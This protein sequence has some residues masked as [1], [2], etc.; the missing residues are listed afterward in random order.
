MKIG[1]LLY[2]DAEELDIVGPW[3]MFTVW[4]QKFGGP[5]HCLTI[6]E[7]GQ[8]VRCAKGMRIMADT[9]IADCP[10]L[11]VLLV[12]G[13]HGTFPQ[14]E[15]AVFMG[16]VREQAQHCRSV[17]SVCTGSFILERA[18]LLTGLQATTY[19]SRLDQL[20]RT[21]VGKVPEERFLLNASD[22][23]DVWTSAGVSA[24]I[25]MSLAFIARTAGEKT[26][27]KVQLYAEY[28]PSTQ[29]YGTAHEQ[30]DVPAYLSGNT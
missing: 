11:D 13:G 21:R 30:P 26:A 10:P 7:D 18:E 9:S 24:G 27:G 28:Y 22:T 6:S 8:P 29:R 2:H 12:P 14:L 15:N 5:T 25:D 20:R 17:L 23:L 19:W 3:E 4:S 16:F 1:F